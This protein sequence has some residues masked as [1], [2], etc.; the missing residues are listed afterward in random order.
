[1]QDVTVLEQ[2]PYRAPFPSHPEKYILS[3]I[4]DGLNV[5]PGDVL[6]Y[7]AF[8]S[9]DVIKCENSDISMLQNSLQTFH[10]SP[11][12]VGG[13]KNQICFD[14]SLYVKCICQTA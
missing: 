2:E 13:N 11:P 9:N 7:Q 4:K 6:A 14:I 12:S 3:C 5:S 8:T 10:T 1:V